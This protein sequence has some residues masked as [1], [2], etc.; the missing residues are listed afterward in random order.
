MFGTVLNCL[1]A[2]H[3]Q[4]PCGQHSGPSVPGQSPHHRTQ[5]SVGDAQRCETGV[6]NITTAFTASNNKFSSLVI[7]LNV[8]K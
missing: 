8:L 3:Q 7:R 2:G 4:A 6:R 5:P 1:H